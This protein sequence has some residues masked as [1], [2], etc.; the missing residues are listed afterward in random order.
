MKRLINAKHLSEKPNV[1]NLTTAGKFWLD[2]KR[3]K[4]ITIST[5]THNGGKMLGETPTA[6]ALSGCYEVSLKPNLS[7]LNKPNSVSL[8]A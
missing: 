1:L 8:S 3:R 5:M 4:R 6:A 2:T 7:R